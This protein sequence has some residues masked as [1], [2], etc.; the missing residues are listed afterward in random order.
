MKTKE[1]PKKIPFNLHYLNTVVS[2]KV[3]GKKSQKW[4]QINKKLIKNKMP[5]TLSEIFT[6]FPESSV[7][8]SLPTTVKYTHNTFQGCCM[9]SYTIR[10]ANFL[11]TAVYY[12]PK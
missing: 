12:L 6:D 1:F 2:R 5:C 4:W 3:V 7:N 8:E 10:F 11:E 9:H